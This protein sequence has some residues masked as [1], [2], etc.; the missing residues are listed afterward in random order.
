MHLP[1]TLFLQYTP[2]GPPDCFQFT[3]GPYAQRLFRVLSFEEKGV[4]VGERTR[5]NN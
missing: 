4:K 3:Y 1:W 2:V 5:D